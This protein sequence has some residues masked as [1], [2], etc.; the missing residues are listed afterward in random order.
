MQL[1]TFVLKGNLFAAPMAGVTDRPFRILC[2]QFGAALAVSEMV[3]SNAQLWKSAKTQRRTDHRGEAEPISV[4]IAG[5]D[6]QQMADAARYNVDAGAQII[7]INMGCPVKKVCNA[8]AGSALL[9]DE[10]LVADILSAVVRAVP[11]PVTLKYRTGWD[12]ASKNAVRV[13]RIAEDCGI[14]LLA[15]H[16]R[17]RACGFSGHAEYDSIAEVKAATKLPIIANGD[18]T[19]P[20]EAQRVLKHTAADG[21][22]IGRGAQGRPWIFRDI[23]HY[24]ATGVLLAPPTID[25]TEAVLVQHV[26]ALHDFYGPELGVRFARKHVAWYTKRW[27]G[28]ET[29]RERF[30]RLAST[31]EQ[32][33]AIAALFEHD[34]EC[35]GRLFREEEKLAA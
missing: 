11:V 32:L 19:T 34:E 9:R 30:N 27:V 3:T 25:E 10:A 6:P 13:A 26:Q 21:I 24:L 8:M 16:G 1:G 28:A 35:V 7:D 4:Q 12:A 17:T 20:E 18:I 31:E 15:L 29:F 2:K 5:A 14:R 23:S 33:G 22:M